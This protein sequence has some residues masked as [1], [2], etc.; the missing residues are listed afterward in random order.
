MYTVDRQDSVIQLGDVLPFSVGAP[1][2]VALVDDNTLMVAYYMEVADP[3]WDGS[4][5]RAIDPATSVG[6]VALVTFTAYKAMMFG[7]PNDEAFSGHPLAH[8]GLQPYAAH[9]VR[10]SSWIRSLERLNSVHPQHSSARYES[11][12]HFIFSFQDSTLECVAS[13]YSVSRHE[14]S[15]R[16]VV[17][18]MMQ[19]LRG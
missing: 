8:R 7:P 16:G 10:T 3:E 13:G 12:R 18:T 5:V 2:P 6:P 19:R 17:E 14:G 11:L 4:S 15:P 9:E 1:C